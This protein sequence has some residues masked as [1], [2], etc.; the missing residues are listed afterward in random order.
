MNNTVKMT[1]IAI[2]FSLGCAGHPWGCTARRAEK[3]PVKAEDKSAAKPD[4]IAEKAPAPQS[5]EGTDAA[6]RKMGAPPP[7]AKSA[8][9]PPPPAP[10]SADALGATEGSGGRAGSAQ[11]GESAAPHR[12]V[13]YRMQTASHKTMKVGAA[14]GSGG[15]AFW[16]VE[17][18]AEKKGWL[19][20]HPP[21]AAL[22]R[23]W[24]AELARR[25]RKHLLA[26]YLTVESVTRTLEDEE[27]KQLVREGMKYLCGGE[28]ESLVTAGT[29]EKAHA[30]LSV[31]YELRR[32]SAGKVHLV[33]KKRLRPVRPLAGDA[34][35]VA[36]LVSLIES[37]A[38]KIAA[39]VAEHIP[40]D[41]SAVRG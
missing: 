20:A 31:V 24:G 19:A 6:R 23:D 22:D 36:D 12:K 7:D 26:R 37:A 2:V 14:A 9:A 13:S 1:A 34:I 35:S 21:L 15:R 17:Q 30:G 33:Q 18:F 3:E 27:I 10:G 5:P 29:E 28:I 16:V 25:L 40:A 38:E 11:Y 32:S 39:R 8:G 41:L 4:T